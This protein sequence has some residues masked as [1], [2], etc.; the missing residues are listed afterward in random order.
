MKYCGDSETL[1]IILTKLKNIPASLLG[2]S[3]TVRYALKG[4]LPEILD[5]EYTCQPPGLL[6]YCQVRIKG[7]PL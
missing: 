5:K 7:S 3:V 4:V 2:S 6:C 1:Q